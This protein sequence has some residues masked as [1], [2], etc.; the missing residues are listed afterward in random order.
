MKFNPNKINIMKMA[1]GEN[2]IFLDIT[3]NKL[4]ESTSERDPGEGHD[5]LPFTPDSHE[6]GLEGGKPYLG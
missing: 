6:N 3:G 1:E 4:Q 5:A 2:K